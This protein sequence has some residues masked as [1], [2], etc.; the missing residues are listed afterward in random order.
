MVAPAPQ[1]SPLEERDRRHEERLVA[2][3]DALAQRVLE[4]DVRP[5]AAAAGR[6][7]FPVELRRAED[8]RGWVAACPTIPGCVTQGETLSGAV[9][10]AREAIALCLETRAAEGSTWSPPDAVAVVELDAPEGFDPGARAARP[11]PPADDLAAEVLEGWRAARDRGAILLPGRLLARTIALLERA[12]ASPRGSV[13]L[14]A[15]EGAADLKTAG[16]AAED[17]RDTRARVFDE[18]CAKRRARKAE[19]ASDLERGLRDLAAAGAI[20][21]R[22]LAE[23]SALVRTGDRPPRVGALVA[24]EEVPPG[25]VAEIP[26]WGSVVVRLASGRGWYCCGTLVAFGG[27]EW[28]E[29]RIPRGRLLAT[30][31]TAEEA[32]QVAGMTPEAARAWCFAAW[33]RGGPEAAE[34]QPVVASEPAGEVVEATP[35]S[36]PVDAADAL[37]RLRE[38]QATALPTRRIRVEHTQPAV[39]VLERAVAEAGRPAA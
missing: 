19:A 30:D 24:A 21:G 35:T 36:A 31:L 18:W 14:V 39:E 26:G 5:P 16:P 37:A 22:A 4:L 2:A 20:S 12:Y 11:A 6:L 23:V 15:A 9:D 8:G 34:A 38:L 25:S 33:L 27:W 7:A 29:H 13:D 28:Q 3:T 1:P 10:A 17:L 32:E